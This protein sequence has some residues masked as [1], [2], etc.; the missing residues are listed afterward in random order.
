[1]SSHPRESC[2]SCHFLTKNFN[3][4]GGQFGFELKPAEEDAAAKN[5]FPWL[6]QAN[7]LK[8]CKSVWDEGYM[9]SPERRYETLVTTAPEC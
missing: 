9:T 8:S 2:V 7:S 6:G 1:M 3:K 4:P 5:D